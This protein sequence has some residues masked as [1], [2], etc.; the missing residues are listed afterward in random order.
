MKR[1]GATLLALGLVVLGAGPAGGAATNLVGDWQMNESPGATVMVDASRHQN[2]TIGSHV[3]VGVTFSG[4]TGYAWPF[5]SPTQPPAEP[6][7]LVTI[8]NNALY[9]PGTAD[10]AVTIKYRSTQHFGN[11]IQKGQGGASGG[12]WKVENPQGRVL[13]KFRGRSASGVWAAKTVQSPAVLSDGRWHV[14][15]CERTSTKLTMTV[16]GVLVK[17]ANGSSGNITNTRPISIAG[18]LNCDNVST[19]C[20]YFTGGL[21]Y[22]KIERGY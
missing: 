17:T 10:F 7:R 1:I 9:N 4:E 11:I 12:Y 21:G 3:Q 5:R 14:I 8:P 19:T 16:D 2:G 6:E 13:C 15:R 20:D 18:K 22:V